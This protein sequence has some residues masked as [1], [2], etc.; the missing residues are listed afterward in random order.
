ML[1]PAGDSGLKLG[2]L[3]LQ[4]IDF[5]AGARQQLSLDVEFLT[6]N[7]LETAQSL[8][9]DIVK[10]GA[11]IL[12]RVYQPWRYQRNKSKG[13]LIDILPVHHGRRLELVGAQCRNEVLEIAIGRLSQ[14]V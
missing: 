5:G 12:V 1:R 14:N 7:Q 10:I 2:H 13:N 6:G 4:L 11:Q 9:Q 3:L 8:C